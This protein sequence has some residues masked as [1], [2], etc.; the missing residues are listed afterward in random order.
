MNKKDILKREKGKRG[1]RGFRDLLR[2]YGFSARRGQQFSGSP[3][4]PDVV[5]PELPVHFE[6][7]AGNTHSV[8]AAFRQCTSECGGSVPVVSS[9]R[10]Y[11]DWMVYLR[12]SD[13]LEI[14]R[15]SDIVLSKKEEDD[16]T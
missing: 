9:K 15:R 3:D 2:S 11:G 1:E 7:K 5:C 13:F 14:V 4:S 12:A 10:D 6:V 8:D 16:E